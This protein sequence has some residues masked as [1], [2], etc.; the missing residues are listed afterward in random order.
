MVAQAEDAR[1]ATLGLGG[2]PRRQLPSSVPLGPLAGIRPFWRHQQVCLLADDLG[3][4]TRWL[5]GEIATRR[6][7]WHAANGAPHGGRELPAYIVRNE[8]IIEC[9]RRHDCW[10]RKPTYSFQIPKK[11]NLR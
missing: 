7:R 10:T 2:R 8:L 4:L 11:S 3:V 6:V 9:K 5:L 1:R